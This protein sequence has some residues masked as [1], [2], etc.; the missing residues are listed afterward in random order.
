MMSNC[1]SLSG[2]TELGCTYSPTP[3]YLCQV[4][5]KQLAQKY[6]NLS[7]DWIYSGQ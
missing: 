1:I 4:H 7:Y 6:D 5:C 2:F 3:F